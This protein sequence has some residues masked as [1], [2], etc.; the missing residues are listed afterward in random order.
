MK[1]LLALVAIIGLNFTT[2]ARADLPG[3]IGEVLRDK[4]MA[5]V[6]A[7]IAIARLTGSRGE[8]VYH[9]DSAVLHT[10]ASNLKIVTTSA[11]LAELGPDFKFRTCLL[12]R[13]NDLILWGDGDPTLGDPNLPATG[14]ASPTAVFQRWIDALK[15]QGLT[16][17]RNVLV[18]DSVF[19][20]VFYHPHWAENQYTRP[21]SAEVAGMSLAANCIQLT[22]HPEG[23]RVGYT[24]DPETKYVTVKNSCTTGRKSAVWLSRDKDTNQLTLRGT[25][26]GAGTYAV[27][28]HDPPLY[29]AQV[30]A[31]LLASNGITVTGQA[32][33]DRTIRAAYA[34][35]PSEFNVLAMYQTPLWA[36]IDRANK[37]S[38]N[39]Y[40]ESL[41]KRLGFA[42]TGKSG[43]WA[44]GTA[45]VGN[46]LTTRAGVSASEFHLDDGCG[47]SHENRISPNAILHVLM[48]DFYSP[49]REEFMKSL[50]VAGEDGTLEHRFRRS[51]LDG[52]VFAKTGFV[53]GVSC[54]SGFLKTKSNQWYAFSIMFNNIPMYSNSIYK[55]IEERI[56]SA[57]DRNAR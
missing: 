45:A 37:D 39:L 11:A 8:V 5:R 9:H 33:R 49:N 35:D 43:S 26:A 31:D 56:V 55:P 25:A 30:F 24:L 52:R 7:G 46:F 44:S 57:I 32:V 42:A 41:C 20:D 2:V 27:T 54:L 15:K 16:R 12:Q 48:Y 18:D 10:P 6:E 19:D 3:D 53:N 36:V 4:H 14:H 40:A 29:A 23:G 17:V 28:I 50:A 1:L 13:G 47:L 38:M 51:D 22:V 34:H 21:Y